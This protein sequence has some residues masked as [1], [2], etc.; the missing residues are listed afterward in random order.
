[1][2]TFAFKLTCEIAFSF[3]HSQH[4]KTASKDFD[5]VCSCCG[6]FTDSR[7]GVSEDAPDVDLPHSS[8]H[9]RQPHLRGTQAQPAP[10]HPRT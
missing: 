4:S 5:F 7:V 2:K 1:M 8:V 3:L 9:D 10:A 6:W